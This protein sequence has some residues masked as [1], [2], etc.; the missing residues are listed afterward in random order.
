MSEV[1]DTVVI[2]PSSRDYTRIA[3]EVVGQHGMVIGHLGN[4]YAIVEPFEDPGGAVYVPEPAQIAR[5]AGKAKTGAPER[6]GKA[7]KR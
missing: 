1:G 6:P 3:K 4:K 5:V 7:A 2:S